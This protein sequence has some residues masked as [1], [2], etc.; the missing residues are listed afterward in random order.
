VKE[1]LFCCDLVRLALACFAER[2]DGVLFAEAF[3][4][5]CFFIGSFR[6]SSASI[7]GEYRSCQ[8]AARP[9]KSQKLTR[10]AFM[11]AQQS[12]VSPFRI[13][14]G[15]TRGTYPKSAIFLA[16]IWTRTQGVRRIRKPTYFCPSKCHGRWSSA[17]QPE[18]QAPPDNE[19]KAYHHLSR[20]EIAGGKRIFQHLSV[21]SQGV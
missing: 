13:R 8:V 16:Q 14:L 7:V 4:R 19:N 18:P 15:H 5:V 17:S 1:A 12:W 9:A 6:P 20:F 21:C 11:P 2:R 3:F 10:V